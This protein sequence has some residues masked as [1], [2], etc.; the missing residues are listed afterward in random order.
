LNTAPIVIEQFYPA[1]L[2]VVWKAI[3][4]ENQMRRWFFDSM[5][6]FKAEV[7]F[8]TRFDVQVEGRVFP[9]EW[10]VTDVQPQS[11]IVYDWR[12]GG[13]SGNSSVTWEL[14]PTREGT[15]L[16]MTHRGHETFPQD[17]PMFN[18]EACV[19]GWRYFLQESLK[20]FLGDKMILK[21][22]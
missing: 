1:P 18:R 11:R 19:A 4:D 3:T 14:W 21:A 13:Y 5:N 16:L 15:K 17:D 6:D 7:G 2:A 22:T 10:R 9:H 8:E 20:A 12:Y